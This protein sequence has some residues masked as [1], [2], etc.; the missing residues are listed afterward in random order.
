[1]KLVFPKT[2]VLLLKT[3]RPRQWIKNLSMF[4]ALFFSGF[5]FEDGYFM[6]VVWAFLLFTLVT[7]SVYIFNDIVDAPVD[8]LHPFKKKRPLASG[9]LSVAVAAFTAIVGFF[10][11]LFF[12]WN[13]NVFFFL[14]VFMYAVLHFG[15]TIWLKH[16]PILD[17]LSI[18][19]GFVVRV[20]AGA[21]VVNLHMSVWF[22]F[23]VVSLAL[24]MAVG[25]RQSERTL[26]KGLVGNLQGH[27]NTLS[28]YTQRLLDIYTGMFAN[29]TWLSYALFSFNF[30]VFTPSGHLLSLYT[31]L[32]QTFINAKLMMATVPLVIYGVM[33]YLQLVYEQ[34]KGESPER[35]LLSDKPLI[36]AVLGY[37]L[38]S[39]MIIYVLS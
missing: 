32:P 13:Y 14:M 6:R 33:R 21:L 2:L 12:A 11:A 19:S 20:Y 26:I 9:D 3:A 34:N 17:V 15:Y 18:A 35:V 36:A 27:R 23:T 39:F 10:V 25:K 24:F 7:A 31:V 22:L 4:A 38:L 37:G 8:R 1:M 16:V 30:A 5:M 29:A 28:R